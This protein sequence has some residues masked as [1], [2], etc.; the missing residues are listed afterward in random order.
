MLITMG[1]YKG[2][3]P[4]LFSELQAHLVGLVLLHLLG[5]ATNNQ[6]QLTLRF[7][8]NP[9]LAPYLKT[10]NLVNDCTPFDQ[11]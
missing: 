9:P 3:I 8:S 7:L 6:H 2:P 10:T 4:I 11:L 1:H 5:S